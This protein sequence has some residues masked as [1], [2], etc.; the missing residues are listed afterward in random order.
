MISNNNPRV[1][2]SARYVFGSVF[3]LALFAVLIGLWLNRRQYAPVTSPESLKLLQLLNTACNT[4][5]EKRL[6]VAEQQFAKLDREG[7]LSAGE[8]TGYERIIGLA[9]A[10][11]WK[12]A[13]EE[14][15][16][17]AR[18]QVGV[19]HPTPPEPRAKR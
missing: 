14:A 15:M 4:Q 19:G 9:R 18:D 17:M 8:K 3:A 6:A 11:Q 5:D 7:K 10:G 2:N 16:R 13:E 12:T 1:R